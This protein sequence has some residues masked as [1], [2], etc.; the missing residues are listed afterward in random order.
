MVRAAVTAIVSAAILAG[1]GVAYSAES[2]SQVAREHAPQQVAACCF[3][4]LIEE[5]V[6]AKRENADLT[7]QLAAAKATLNPAL[8]GSVR[9]ADADVERAEVSTESDNADMMRQP[10]QKVLTKN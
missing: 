2:D 7:R 9:R 10:D 8:S 1:G 5:L 4:K 3:I 6:D